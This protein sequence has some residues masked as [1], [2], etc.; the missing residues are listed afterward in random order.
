MYVY[1]RVPALL[2]DAFRVC[3]NSMFLFSLLRFQLEITKQ[4][5]GD[6]AMID[7]PVVAL[8]L[9]GSCKASCSIF[10][11][12]VHTLVS[13]MCAK[14]HCRPRSI[15][16]QNS[17]YSSCSAAAIASCPSSDLF[18]LSSNDNPLRFK[19]HSRFFPWCHSLVRWSLSAV[20]FQS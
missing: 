8:V 12:S 19:V 13:F 1:C 6:V 2:F 11:F 10:S 9:D 3:L 7:F 18:A 14:Q 5:C 20:L 15:P 4:V 16:G 17:W